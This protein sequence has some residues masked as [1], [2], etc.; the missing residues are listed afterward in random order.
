MQDPWRRY[1]Y[2]IAF[3]NFV[4]IAG[5]ALANPF[6]P[7]VLNRDLGVADPGMAPS[8]PA[9]QTRAAGSCRRLGLFLP[10]GGEGIQEIALDE[11]QARRRAL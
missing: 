7:L 1:L 2:V 5:S 8:G 4:S 11:G 6:L 10:S 9:A 3:A